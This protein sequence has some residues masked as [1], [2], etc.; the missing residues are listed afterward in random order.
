MRGFVV[1]SAGSGEVGCRDVPGFREAVVAAK[2]PR[3][4]TPARI[5]LVG[6]DD[7]ASAWLERWAEDVEQVR[8]HLTVRR[9][10]GAE[11]TLVA[12]IASFGEGIP[13]SLA[14]ESIGPLGGG[15]V[16]RSGVHPRAEVD[17]ALARYNDGRLDGGAEAPPTPPV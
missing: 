16:L 11:I 1:V 9:A 6:P 2:D 5:A 4:P 3:A 10:D 17:A 13:T 15:G 7:A 14:V 12:T 8:R